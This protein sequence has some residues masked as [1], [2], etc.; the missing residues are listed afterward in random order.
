MKEEKQV[1]LLSWSFLLINKA[2]VLFPFCLLFLTCT[3][4]LTRNPKGKRT[5]IG[6][7]GKREI[8]VTLLWGIN[9]VLARNLFFKWDS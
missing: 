4:P 9:R 1:L 8:T 6:H 7:P 3:A 2:Y 5:D